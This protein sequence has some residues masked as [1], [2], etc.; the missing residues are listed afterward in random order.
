MNKKITVQFTL[1]TLG[2]TLLTWGGMIILGRMGI[3][4]DDH[5]W[6]WIPFLA[7][8]W[9]PTYMSYVLLKRHGEV[10]GPKEWFKNVFYVK[11]KLRYYLFA[12]LL[13]VLYYGTHMVVSGLSEMRPIWMMFVMIPVM[14]GGGG[15]EE[16]GWRY[17]LQPELDR[18]YG[19]LIAVIVTAIIWFAWHVPLFFIPG[20]AQYLYLNLWMF[21]VR[22]LGYTFFFGA[23]TRISG[24]AGIFLSVLAHTLLNSTAETFRLNHT[25]AATF[26][27]FGVLVAVSFITIL[28]YER[29]KNKELSMAT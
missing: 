2:I 4:M 25:W 26:V 13:V 5:L 11:A 1:F 16:A 27:T 9:S 21:A 14:L 12:V 24:K 28:I 6:L 3:L 22:V 18:K 20:T 23:I 19:F 15:M 29:K 10:S 7:G 17:I 8:G